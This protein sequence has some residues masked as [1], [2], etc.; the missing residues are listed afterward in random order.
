[1]TVCKKTIPDW[2]LV[3]NLLLV[4]YWLCRNHLIKLLLGSFVRRSTD[5]TVQSLK[6]GT[7]NRA[8]VLYLIS[9][10][11]KN[12][13]ENYHIWLENCCECCDLDQ[14][15]TRLI[16]FEVWKASH[17]TKLRQKMTFPYLESLY[18][19]FKTFSHKRTST[20]ISFNSEIN[21]WD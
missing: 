15:W 2:M 20:V 18:S 19:I 16:D 1:M 4:G 10:R 12:N 14:I 8:N 21:S 6:E 17:S 5:C 3:F 11:K 13:F 7:Q 9:K